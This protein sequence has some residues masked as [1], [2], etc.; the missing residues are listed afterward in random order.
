REPT[1]AIAQ[2]V[3]HRLAREAKVVAR[4]RARAYADTPQF[5]WPIAERSLEAHVRKLVGE[6][7][8]DRDAGVLSLRAPASGA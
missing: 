3:A 4:L 8:V 1:V 5:L 6:A 2:Y 7:R